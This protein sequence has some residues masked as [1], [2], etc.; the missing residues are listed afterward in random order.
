[1]LVNY[2][3]KDIPSRD[4]VF[5]A[6]RLLGKYDFGDS[7][8]VAKEV[9]AAIKV[10]TELLPKYATYYVNAYDF[11]EEIR[12]NKQYATYKTK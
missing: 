9:L 5:A 8:E 7:I 3:R 2:K 4:K 12:N 10:T 1:M 11:I 6:Q